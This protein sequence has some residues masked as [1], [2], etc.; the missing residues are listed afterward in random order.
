MPTR[1]LPTLDEIEAMASAIN[2]VVPPTATYEWPLLSAR[3]GGPV[4]V[5][6]ENHTAI[7]S[8]KIRGALAYASR[9]VARDPSVAGLIAATRGNFGQAVA[10]AAKLHHLSA[11]VVVP[12]GNSIEKN[13]A[14]RA[15]GAELIEHGEDFQAALVHSEELAARRRLHWVPSYHRDLV[16]GNA[17]STLAF[18]REAPLLARVYVPIGMG[19]GICA[20]ISARDALGLGTKIIGVASERAP[21][22]ALSFEARKVVPHAASTRIAD[23]MA[24]SVPSA[25]ALGHILKGVERIVRV[26]DDEIEAAQRAYF[27]DTHNV[28]EGAAGAGLAAILKDRGAS[29]V[30]PAGVVFTG[31]NI[32]ADSFRR[33][34]SNAG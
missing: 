33:V 17:V 16:L 1:S 23:G 11:T 30:E 12:H 18:L 26:T 14:M 28:A 22:I 19:S 9:L 4:W 13:L 8:F 27:S 31:G 21:A 29:S 25:E 2:A 34:L 20:M 15:L 5:K 3:A 6:H 32:D 7:G 10:F 24:C